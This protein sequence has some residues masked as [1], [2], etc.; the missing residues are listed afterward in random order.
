MLMLRWNAA[1]AFATYLDRNSSLYVGRNVLELG[2]GGGLPGIVT[3]LN[4]AARVSA[5]FACFICL[6]P[7]SFGLKVVLT[8]YPD[9]ALVDN[10]AGNVR[11]NV[12][13]QT[14]PNISVTVM[15]LTICRSG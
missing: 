3:A 8:D 7:M 4:G 1:R 12:P 14:L 9:T 6:F 13:P 10:L 5:S 15:I 2:A 11:V